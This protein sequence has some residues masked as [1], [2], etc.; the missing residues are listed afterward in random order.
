M[1]FYTKPRLLSWEMPS[2]PCVAWLMGAL[3]GGDEAG[4]ASSFIM[5]KSC[6][7]GHDSMLLAGAGYGPA[8]NKWTR[9]VVQLLFTRVCV[10][11][12]WR[13]VPPLPL[14]SAVLW[15]K[16]WRDSQC[17][18]RSAPL[19]R[20]R[21]A[22]IGVSCKFGCQKFLL[23][24]GRRRKAA[25]KED[26]ARFQIGSELRRAPLCSAIQPG[27]KVPGKSSCDWHCWRRRRRCGRRR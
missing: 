1:G 26:E 25:R 6:E 23:V 8:S 14:C 15:F 17:R 22:S 4:F 11:T 10:A 5:R 21:T 2:F 18:R 19:G 13:R 20:R 7:H 24:Q 27:R 16:L 12:C 3:L 9:S